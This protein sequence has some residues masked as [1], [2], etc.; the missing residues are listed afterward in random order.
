M[1]PDTPLPDGSASNT[2]GTAG[3]DIASL[4]LF[5]LSTVL[6]PQGVLNLQIFEVRY[7]DMIGK[8]YKNGTPFG[9]VSLVKGAEVRRMESP[10]TGAEGFAQE[11]F[12]DVGTLAI[13]TEYSAPQAGLMVVRCS[14]TERFRIRSRSQLKHGLWTADVTTLAPDADTAIPPDLQ[15]LSAA[16]ARLLD[17]QRSG[18]AMFEPL[19][20]D[21]PYR[22]EDCGWVANRW[23]DLLSMPPPMKQSLMQLDNPFLRLELVGDLMGSNLDAI[24]R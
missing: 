5:P 9:V 19:P 4:P 12:A 24:G 18:E 21:P 17:H 20:I 8:C 10:Q 3:R 22:F 23:C 2:H 11:Q 1:H 6:M 7:L 15:P 16:L 14:G 13:I